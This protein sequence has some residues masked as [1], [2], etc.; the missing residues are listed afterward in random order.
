MADGESH[1]FEITMRLLIE[2]TASVERM[3]THVFP[4]SQY[5]DALAAASNRK[6]SRSVKVLLDP[7]G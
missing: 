6:A 5:R 3:I 7:S 4:L 1:T 2:S